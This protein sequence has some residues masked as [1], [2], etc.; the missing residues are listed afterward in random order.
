MRE[1]TQLKKP[2]IRKNSY[3]SLYPLISFAITLLC[4]VFLYWRNGIRPI[5]QGSM[6]SSDLKEQYATFLVFWKKQLASIDPNNFIS[7]L[8]YSK[9]RSLGN[10]MMGTIGYYLISPLN[11]VLFFFKSRDIGIAVAVIMLL[12]LSLASAFMC[13]FL[14]RRVSYRYENIEVFKNRSKLP[15]ILGVA[16]AFTSFSIIFIFNIMWFDGYY[17]L[18]LILYFLEGFIRD[19]KYKGLVVSLVVLF[20]TN[21]YIAYMVGIFSFIYLM[22]RLLE[23]DVSVSSVIHNRSSVY[24]VV[25]YAVLAVV[26]ALICAVVLVPVAINTLN[27]S[28]PTVINGRSEFSFTAVDILEQ[29]FLGSSG[30]FSKLVNNMPFFF[31]SILVNLS[32]LIY[33]LSDVF[34]KR[35]KRIRLILLG[36]CFCLFFISKLDVVCQAFDYPN[37]F[38]HRYSFVFYPFFFVFCLDVMRE[39]KRITDKSIIRAAL[40]LSSLLV[41][42]QSVSSIKMEE[43]V[44]LINFCTIVLYAVILILLKKEHWSEQF[45]DMPKILPVMFSLVV[46]IEVA[47]L[48]TALINQ[49][50][51]IY[52][53]NDEFYASCIDAVE[54]IGAI[55]NQEDLKEGNNEA[56]YYRCEYEDKGKD[57]Y[58]HDVLGCHINIFADVDGV[59][60]F[61]TST[62][63]RLSC[64]FKQLGYWDNY[65]YA[66]STYNYA[67][68][69]TD[70]FL[71][72]KHV[73]TEPEYSLAEPVTEETVNVEEKRYSDAVNEVTYRLYRNDNVLPLAFPVNNEAMNFDFYALENRTQDKNY[74]TFQDE[75]YHSMFPDS[76]NRSMFVFLNENSVEGPIVK[77][78]YS[79]VGEEYGHKSFVSDIYS[80]SL[81]SEDVKDYIPTLNNFAPYNDG[82]P[83]IVTYNLTVPQSGEL[84]MNLASAKMCNNFKVFV[85]GEEFI[86]YSST[87]SQITRVGYYEAGSKVE[88][89]I[90]ADA[91]IA[92][93][94]VNFA[95]FDYE[96]F[97]SQFDKLE[98]SAVS[99]NRYTDGYA[100]LSVDTS[101]INEENST[102]LTTIPY[103]MGWSLYI[104]GRPAEISVY[105]NALIAIELNTEGNRLLDGGVHSIELRFKTPGIELGAICS[106]VGLVLLTLIGVYDVKR[107]SKI[108]K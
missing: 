93:A 21:Y 20:L 27:F 63:R 91:G 87:F 22:V 55:S 47:I 8:T 65:N 29:L 54:D 100:E 17:L 106:I 60:F 73:I 32:I 78:G 12:K 70:A 31:S 10:N 30:E 88:V 94:A 41:I 82:F 39:L 11:I 2:K 107:I 53:L 34:D 35:I 108:H 89:S 28:D 38:C 24:L 90:V 23:N 36:V 74:F 25:K 102:I 62:N 79:F 1:Q 66:S 71:A 86:E 37:W 4:M 81:G 101:L 26:C 59:S 96:A 49:S 61:N 46:I 57:K 51:F 105:Q 56:D 50:R 43:K 95:I 85:D 76:F 97:D 15:I 67:M 9:S 42:I 77:Q 18:P 13:M 7:S 68:P 75:W 48:N 6:L 99:V 98:T 5:G 52:A 64:F 80:D 92:L 16:Y 69:N 40:V 72:L 84:Y 103:D 19:G 44:I 3:L 83:V 14:E 104:D 33:F 58:K 45:K